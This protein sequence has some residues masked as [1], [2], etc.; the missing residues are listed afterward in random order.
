MAIFAF[1]LKFIHF[2]FLKSYATEVIIYETLLLVVIIYLITY[3]VI[4]L[5]KRMKKIDLKCRFLNL[6]KGTDLSMSDVK[7]NFSN[8]E[9]RVLGFSKTDINKIATGAGMLSEVPGCENY[10]VRIF[11]D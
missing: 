2:G 11:Y 9:L 4:V 6:S 1:L 7:Y 3:W 10:I 8:E 5:N